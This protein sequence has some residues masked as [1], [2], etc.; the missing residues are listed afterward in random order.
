MTRYRERLSATCLTLLIVPGILLA[1]PPL[2]TVQDVL[3]KADGTRFNGVAFIE[4]RSFQASD[5][6]NIAT[7]SVTVPIVDGNLRVQL[8]P[9]TTASAGAS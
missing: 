2:A 3:Y 5:L 6:S 7:H 1:A 8:V 4:W 9:T